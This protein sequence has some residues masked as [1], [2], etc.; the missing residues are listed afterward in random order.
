MSTEPDWQSYIPEVS[1]RPQQFDAL[2][3]IWDVLYVQDRR[4]CIL[5]APTG[6]GKSLIQLALCRHNAAHGKRSYIVTPQRV[7]QDQMRSWDEVAVMKGKSSYDCRL[8]ASCSA[9]TAPC[10]L[11]SDVRNQ[12]AG[13]CSVGRCPYFT[14]LDTAQNSS[15]VVHNY[16]SLLSQAHIGR[17]FTTRGLLCLDEGH[18]AVDWI[19]NYMTVEMTPGDVREL[20]SLSP[21]EKIELFMPWLRWILSNVDEVPKGLSDQLKVTLM[22]LLAW[23]KPFGLLTKLQLEAMFEEDPK[24]ASYEADAKN[25]LLDSGDVPF[26]TVWNEP[27]KWRD[28]G[29]WT[30]IPLRVAPMAGAL[31]ELGDKVLVVTATVLNRPLL[32]AELGLNAEEAGL[33][34]IDSAFEPGNRP[35][36]RR[37]SGKMSQRHQRSTFPK[38]IDELCRIAARHHDEPGMVH[39]VSHRLSAEIC[40]ELRNRLGGRT[41]EQL[42]TGGAREL[43]IHRFLSGGLGPNAIL[44]GP[45]L[46][47]GV[48]GEG[49]SCRWQAMCKV[50]WPFMG[51]PVVKYIRSRPGQTAKSW[52]E[53]WYTWKAAQATVQGIGRVCRT[54]HDFGTTY[55]LDSGFDTILKSKYVPDYVKAAIT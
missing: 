23:R 17:H 21:P 27:T 51:D 22:R 38:L 48:D 49:D 52:A 8:V 31:T 42:P 24:F 7:L 32:A 33:V 2:S 47:E 14:A 37:Y 46:I 28:E 12:N 3:Q 36:V 45:S 29:W 34:M 13:D 11:D 15:V 26:A 39:T 16:A 4:V 25:R 41:V 5:E 43:I 19:R 1:L 53:A 6:V 54:P 9:A 35:I 18:T 50:P 30:T 40:Y 55:L 20:T 10:T 44:V